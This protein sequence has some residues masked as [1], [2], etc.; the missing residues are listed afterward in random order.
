M[1]KKTTKKKSK[2]PIRVTSGEPEAKKISELATAVEQHM[3]TRE[4]EVVEG[5]TF[6]READSKVVGDVFGRP[7]AL[8]DE[9][10]DGDDED[11]EGVDWS[12]DPENPDVQK[13]TPEELDARIAKLEAAKAERAEG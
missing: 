4:V 2:P 6:T 13:L 8:D 9:D 12:V 1:K 10:G 11:D 5:P 3:E 7:S